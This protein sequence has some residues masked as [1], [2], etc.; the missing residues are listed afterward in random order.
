MIIQKEN[1]Q[2]DYQN[3][4]GGNGDL[5][6]RRIIRTPEDLMGKGR[7]FSHM[8]LQPNQSVGYHQHVG[9]AEWYYIIAGHG[10]YNDNGK[11]IPVGTGDVCICPEGES[12]GMVNTGEEPL[13]MIALVLYK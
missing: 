3:V 10:E 11:I 6:F 4:R 2:I 5:E 9:D 1:V 12:H 13:E 7:L 8:V